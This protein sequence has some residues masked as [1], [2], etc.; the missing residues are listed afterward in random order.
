M[1]VATKLTYGIGLVADVVPTHDSVQIIFQD[2]SIASLDTSHPHFSV[3]RINAESRRGRLMPVGIVGI[4][5]LM[6]P[7]S[8]QA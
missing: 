8:S 7:P 3:C 1:T 2:G 6:P 4:D 5:M